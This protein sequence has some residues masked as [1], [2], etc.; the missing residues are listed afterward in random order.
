MFLKSL[1]RWFNHHWHPK[2]ANNKRNQDSVTSTANLFPIIRPESLS[3]PN[4]LP[5]TSVPKPRR[6]QLIHVYSSLFYE[7]RV[8]SAVEIQLS[9][10][11]SQPLPPGKIRWDDI[12]TQQRITAEKW[13]SE[14]AEIQEIVK[15][16]QVEDHERAMKAWQDVNDDIQ[17]LEKQQL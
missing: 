7:E 13:A 15:L 2:K 4:S 10:E 12:V 9:I 14:T 1:K 6:K 11:H 8:K 3:L 17:S 5:S 16:K